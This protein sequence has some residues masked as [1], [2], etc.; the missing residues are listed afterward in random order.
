[1]LLRDLILVAENARYLPRLF[2]SSTPSDMDFREAHAHTCDEPAERLTATQLLKALITGQGKNN[3]TGAEVFHVGG[4]IYPDERWF[5]VNGILTDRDMATRNAMCLSQLFG[6][7]FTVVHNP[8][9]G[10]APDLVECVFER[11]FDETCPVSLD[12][13]TELVRASLAGFKVRVIA[14]SQGGIIM[15][16]VLRMMSELAGSPIDDFEVYTF[17]NGA[18]E[19]VQVPGVYQE[20]F[21]NE[22]DFVSRIG[23]LKT[24][25]QSD[26]YVRREVGHL[27]NRDYLEHFASGRFCGKHSRLYQR[28]QK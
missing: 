5:F 20:H 22:F 4:H 10:L 14:H 19:D 26:V 9:Y 7:S 24:G 17:G 25:A 3:R 13:Y 28:L 6:R 12:L 23:I 8:S 16:R 27:L 18:D 21:A 11:T 15:S 2:T 1:M